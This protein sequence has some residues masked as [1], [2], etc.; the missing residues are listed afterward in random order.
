MNTK[1]KKV[2][3]SQEL[4]SARNAFVKVFKSSDTF[5]DPFQPEIE[6][7]IILYHELY[8]LD[9][10]HYYALSEITNELYD[11]NVAFISVTEGRQEKGF[12]EDRS[13]IIDLRRYPYEDFSLTEKN[14][15]ALMETA[16][17]STQG[18]WG[19]VFSE[20]GHAIMGG[21]HLFMDSFKKKI[22]EMQNEIYDFLSEVKSET[23]LSPRTKNY[24][25]KWL[26]K[27]LTSIYGEDQ[28]LVLQKKVELDLSDHGRG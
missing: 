27:L 24:F 23:T 18:Q 22:P 12:H 15:M 19:I 16:I 9:E 1:P 17:Y 5:S 14:L 6:E 13:W 21:S 25:R 8:Q 4:H 11:S 7:K 28:A 10:E 2:K 26:P 3:S 20:Y